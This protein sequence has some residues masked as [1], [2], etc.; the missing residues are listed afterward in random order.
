M[1][2][3]TIKSVYAQDITLTPILMILISYVILAR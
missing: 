3:I 1:S 2:P